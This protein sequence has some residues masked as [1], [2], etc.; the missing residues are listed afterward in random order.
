MT[1]ILHLALKILYYYI[2]VI[3]MSEN[4]ESGSEEIEA[5]T[6]DEHEVEEEREEISRLGL[7]NESDRAFQRLFNKSDQ[8]EQKKPEKKPPP[9]IF[10]VK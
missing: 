3:D 10:L 6:H 9:D 8:K 1:I 5:I 7:S 4:D 2:I